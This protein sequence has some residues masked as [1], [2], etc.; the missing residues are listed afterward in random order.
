MNELGGLA[1]M[2]VV[3]NPPYMG[4]WPKKVGQYMLNFGA[5]ELFS[6]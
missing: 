5:I 1:S 6:Y 4:D 2:G 3:V